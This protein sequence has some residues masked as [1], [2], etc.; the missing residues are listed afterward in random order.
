MHN[1][2]FSAVAY[3][4][5][6]THIPVVD[7]IITVVFLCPSCAVW[8]HSVGATV[9]LTAVQLQAEGTLGICG[10]RLRGAEQE[11]PSVLPQPLHCITAAG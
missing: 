7:V 1:P 2:T 4:P 5:A 9:S 3:K 6:W 11:F 10:K 8:G